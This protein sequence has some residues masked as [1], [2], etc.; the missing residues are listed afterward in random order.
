MNDRNRAID[1]L[2]RARDLLAERLTERIL[3]SRDD[4]LADAMGLAYQSEIDAVYEQVGARLNHVSAMLGS[5]PPED[6]PKDEQA[7]GT[8]TGESAVTGPPALPAPRPIAGYLAAREP[9][10]FRTF[11]R[12]VQSGDIGGAGASLAILFDLSPERGQRCAEHFFTRL[13]HEPTVMM[14][15]QGLRQ[16][17]ATNN[18]NASLTLLWECFGLQGM[19]SIAVIQALRMH[20]A[21]AAQSE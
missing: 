10:S 6:E 11:G 13:R 15:A 5:L 9:I 1:V 21:T 20:L 19:E 8:Q 16:E 3:E 17:L 14:K 12:Q 18:F 7:A 4:L 2:K